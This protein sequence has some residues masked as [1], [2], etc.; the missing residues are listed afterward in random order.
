MLL[1]P[2]KPLTTNTPDT[3]LSITIWNQPIGTVL[4]AQST[5]AM[6]MPYPV[7]IIQSQLDASILSLTQN[8]PV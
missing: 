3:I 5:Q 4:N 2:A 1:T 8:Y 6:S 7:I